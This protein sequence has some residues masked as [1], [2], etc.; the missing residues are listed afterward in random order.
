MTTG[1]VFAIVLTL[2]LAACA[3]PERP[4]GGPED[5]KPPKVVAT[6]PEAGSAGVSED[7]EVRITFD[8]SM[9]R[10]RLERT[11]VFHP[12]V[13]VRKATWKKKTVTLIPERPLHPDTTYVIELKAGFA[14]AHGVRNT[15]GFR[16]A[17]ATSA[18]IDSGMI[19]GRVLFRRN[20]TANGVVRLFALPR[21]TSFVAGA[22]R[23]LR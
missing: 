5:K 12:E 3:I 20:P 6:Y 17:F 22:A 9:T 7:S 13:A 21:D 16:F 19:S 10:A 8:E 2:F 14:D 1:R 23:T 4:P 18:S 11:V 15:D